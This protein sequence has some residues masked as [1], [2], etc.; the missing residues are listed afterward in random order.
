VNST[1]RHPWATSKSIAEILGNASTFEEIENRIA[2]LPTEVDRGAAFEVFAEAWL[3]TQRIPRARQV[4]PGTSVPISVQEKLRLP[5]KD[6]GVDGV[7]QTHS[8][9]AVCY[10]VKFR[11]GRP[12]LNWTELS[13]FFGLADF[14]H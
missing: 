5:L 6:M 12:S 3:A 4:W 11:S 10:Q 7:F 9:E 2:A 1:A 8:D 14:A 13:K